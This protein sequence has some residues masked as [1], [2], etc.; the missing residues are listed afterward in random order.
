MVTRISNRVKAAAVAALMCLT[1]AGATVPFM[2]DNAMSVSA[3]SV[4]VGEK[5]DVGDSYKSFFS[6]FKTDSFDEMIITVKAPYTGNMSFGLG[7]STDEEPYWLEYDGAKPEWVDTEGGEIEVP[8]TEVKMT[9]DKEVQIKIDMSDIKVNPKGKFEFRNYYSADWSSGKEN[10]VPIELISIEVGGGSSS[11]EEDTT[12]KSPS[13]TGKAETVKINEELDDGKNYKSFFSE[14]K[15]AANAK[16]MIITVKAPY[17]GN[18]AFG[19]GVSTDEEPY[20]LEYDGSKPEWVDTEGGEIEVEGTEVKMTKDKEVEIKIDLSE[21]KLNP[22]GKFEFRNYYSADWS[23][24]KEKKVPIELI[25]IALVGDAA[26][27]PTDA[28]EKPTEATTTTAKATTTTEKATTTTAK[29]TTTTEKATTTTAKATTTT[30]KETT[31]TAK[32]T[33]TTTAMISETAEKATTTTATVTETTTKA[34][35][36]KADVK[37]YGDANNDDKVDIMDVIAVNKSL[38]GVTELDAQAKANCDVNADGSV[39]SDDSLWILKLA[40]EMV[41]KDDFPVK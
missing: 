5:L 4:K 33:E 25:S 29:A 40:L 1:V 7:V 41:S 11:S 16:T 12:E 18:L 23:S 24:G 21:I 39:T 9:K 38:L 31:T 6:E 8:G 30:E 34:T 28:A 15:N 22:K 35:E 26:E 2:Y 10:K 17:T 37:T 3:V 19:L 14:F 27:K 20:W 13:S 32:A 36:A